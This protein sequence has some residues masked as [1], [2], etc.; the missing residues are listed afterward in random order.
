MVEFEKDRNIEKEAYAI[1]NF[2]Q[3]L[4]QANAAA[5]S[6]LPEATFVAIGGMSNLE[7]L[8]MNCREENIDIFTNSVGILF[9]QL[10]EKMEYLNRITVSKNVLTDEVNKNFQVLKLLYST[11]SGTYEGAY[12]D[13]AT[14]HVIPSEKMLEILKFK[15]RS[16]KIGER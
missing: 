12:L 1:V 13:L 15:P 3:L 8:I 9:Q 14:L 16:K 2:F 6:Q 7:R 10:E 4:S 5:L 11:E